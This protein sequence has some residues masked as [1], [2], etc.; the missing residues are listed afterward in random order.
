VRALDNARISNVEHGMM[1]AREAALHV[2]LTSAFI[3][4]CSIFDIRFL[5]R[6]E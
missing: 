5:T 4:P 6:S 2:I 1:K 3:I